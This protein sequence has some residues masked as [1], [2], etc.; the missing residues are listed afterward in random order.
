M[1]D[2]DLKLENLTECDS[3]PSPWVIQATLLP[4]VYYSGYVVAGS[5][6][7]LD[8]TVESLVEETDLS[9]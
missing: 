3:I 7:R 6:L 2:C 4:N 1:L 9:G 8:S 5:H